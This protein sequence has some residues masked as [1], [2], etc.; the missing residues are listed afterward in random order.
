MGSLL[1]RVFTC[2]DKFP[3][4]PCVCWNRSYTS[5]PFIIFIVVWKYAMLRFFLLTK[6]ELVVWAF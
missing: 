2:G 3:E 6:V 1:P 4:V 5:T